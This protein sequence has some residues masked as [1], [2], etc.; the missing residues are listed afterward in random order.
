MLVAFAGEFVGVV[1]DVGGGSGAAF[2]PA[3]AIVKE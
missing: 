2:A 3:E 1:V